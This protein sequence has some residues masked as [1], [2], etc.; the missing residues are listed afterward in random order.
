LN[1]WCDEGYLFCVE[2]GYYSY[3]I[4][5]HLIQLYEKENTGVS[6]VEMNAFSYKPNGDVIEG[7]IAESISGTD[8]YVCPELDPQNLT[9]DHIL[10]SL[11]I[12]YKPV[13]NGNDKLG[14]DFLQFIQKDVK[15]KTITIVWQQ[16]KF[17]D[18]N[19]TRPQINKDKFSILKNNN[20]KERF[21]SVCT[22]IVSLLTD[23]T[24]EL[25]MNL[26]TSK[27][28]GEFAKNWKTLEKDCS[29]LMEFW[30]DPKI[31]KVKITASKIEAYNKIKKT[32]AIISVPKNS[33]LFP[34]RIQKW[35]A[36]ATNTF[37]DKEK[38]SKKRKRK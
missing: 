15:T 18:S 31:K 3:L 13:Y 5:G 23:Y 4:P 8:G 7:L 32:A 2:N 21:I 11:G 30:Q 19:Q 20:I 37:Y 36:D 16:A 17:G 12:V 10:K 14:F 29:T 33:T 38:S 22:N 34:K 28:E 25:E 26:L 24:I 35:L 9:K 27:Q 6:I 1:R